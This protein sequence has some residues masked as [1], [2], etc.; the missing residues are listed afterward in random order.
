MNCQLGYS[1][2]GE[3]SESRLIHIDVNTPFARVLTWDFPKVEKT[4][5]ILGQPFS[6]SW[7]VSLVLILLLF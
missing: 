7:Y 1:I 6:G 2:G 5:N 3:T 4:C